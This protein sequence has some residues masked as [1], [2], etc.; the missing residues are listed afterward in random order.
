MVVTKNPVKPYG[1]PEMC[2][3]C[4]YSIIGALL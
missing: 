1:L 2:K 4:E 3:R